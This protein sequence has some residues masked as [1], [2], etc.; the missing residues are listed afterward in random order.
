MLGGHLVTIESAYE[1]DFVYKNVF[2]PN[3]SSGRL[4]ATDRDEDGVWVWATGAQ[5]Q[6]TNWAPGEPDGCGG[7]NVDVCLKADF[8]TFS[9][10]SPSGQ[11]RDVAGA[12]GEYICEF[13][14]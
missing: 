6:F 8:L 2:L 4:G 10:D 13:D 14:S 5:M 12:T 1:N 11:W 7:S 9:S 3:G